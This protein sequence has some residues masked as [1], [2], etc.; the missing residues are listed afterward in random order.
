MCSVRLPMNGSC[1]IASIHKN[2]QSLVPG[3]PKQGGMGTEGD[4][5]DGVT[6]ADMLG[7]PG[8]TLAL[9][10]VLFPVWP[11]LLLNDKR[12]KLP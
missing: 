9:P 8:F 12:S 2:K 5:G 1:A 4:R 10:G 3:A 11:Y 7:C 6:Q